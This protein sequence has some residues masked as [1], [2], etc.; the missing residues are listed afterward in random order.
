MIA[1]LHS[2]THPTCLRFWGS[3]SHEESKWCN[4]VIVEADTD[5]HLHL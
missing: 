1:A 4:Y 5:N 3:R 2:H